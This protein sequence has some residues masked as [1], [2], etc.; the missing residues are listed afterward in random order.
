MK[1]GSPT[2][3]AGRVTCSQA[4]QPTLVKRRI[5]LWEPARLLPHLESGTHHVRSIEGTLLANLFWFL[6][7]KKFQYFEKCGNRH[8]PGQSWIDLLR[9]EAHQKMLNKILT[10]AF[11]SQ[12]ISALRAPLTVVII[13]ADTSFVR[14]A[15]WAVSGTRQSLGSS[16]PWV[17]L[18]HLP[19][20]RKVDRLLAC[21]SQSVLRLVLHWVHPATRF[22]YWGCPLQL[23]ERESCCPQEGSTTPSTRSTR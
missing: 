11:L 13:R 6:M 14:L 16:L 4:P 5:W 8:I 20:F 23:G 21:C 7:S 18:Y 1:S 9:C 10:N 22:H 3:R 12:L 17:V 15:A 2:H 19:A